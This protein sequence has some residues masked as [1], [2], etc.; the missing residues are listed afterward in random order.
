MKKISLLLLSMIFC[1]SCSNDIQK[2]YHLKNL[3]KFCTELKEKSS[4]FT[5]EEWEHAHQKYDAII[6]NID[7][8]DYTDAE[9]E[10]IGQKKGECLGIFAKHEVEIYEKK[11][12][13]ISKQIGGIV[14]GFIDA[15]G[16]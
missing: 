5:E 9:L 6:L 1:I 2:S 4:N 8:Y 15:F 12:H 3:D 13:D 11:V 16:Q 14:E 7:K 10:Y